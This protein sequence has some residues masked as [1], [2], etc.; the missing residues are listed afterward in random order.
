MAQQKCSE[1]GEWFEVNNGLMEYCPKCGSH[2][3]NGEDGFLDDIIEIIKIP[4]RAIGWFAFYVLLLPI[5]MVIDGVRSLTKGLKVNGII[6]FI[7]SGVYLVSFIFSFLDI[8][9]MISTDSD[10]TVPSRPYYL[11]LAFLLGMIIAWVTGYFC[12]KKIERN[13][14]FLQMVFK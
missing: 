5:I 9:P 10:S 4:V 8:Y 2:L 12:A 1:C 13:Y 11:T 14:G 3:N 7:S 6:L